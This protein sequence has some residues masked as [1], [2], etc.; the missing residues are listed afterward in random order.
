M[1]FLRKIGKFL[2]TILW[3]VSFGLTWLAERIDNWVDS[4]PV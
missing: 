2:S 4:E 3:V 1:K